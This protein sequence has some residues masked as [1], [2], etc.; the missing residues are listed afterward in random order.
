MADC[1]GLI[2]L[3]GRLRWIAAAAALL[4]AAAGAVLRR[5]RDFTGIMIEVNKRFYC[6]RNGD[7][8]EGRLLQLR[9]ILEKVLVESIGQV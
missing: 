8:I 2:G 3:A 6:D 5:R 1:R 4:S 7:A 9:Q